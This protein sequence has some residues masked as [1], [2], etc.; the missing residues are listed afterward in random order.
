[1]L[2]LGCYGGSSYVFS[3]VYVCVC[4]CVLMDDITS[5]TFNPR[6]SH[7]LGKST[8]RKVKFV[9]SCEC[10]SCPSIHSSVDGKSDL[11]FQL[12]Y[13]VGLLCSQRFNGRR[14]TIVT[15]ALYFIGDRYSLKVIH[16]CSAYP[17]RSA[18]AQWRELWNMTDFTTN[19][20]LTYI[21]STYISWRAMRRYFPCVAA[22]QLL[23]AKLTL[24][25]ET[26][27]SCWSSNFLV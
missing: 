9:S 16:S 2:H 25:S 27:Q 14:R 3:F 11:D 21:E 12:K 15:A 26:V 13:L 19:L 18:W 1:M 17:S 20:L 23:S 22:A 10:R 5:A 6:C 4:V 8:I 24:W 7:H